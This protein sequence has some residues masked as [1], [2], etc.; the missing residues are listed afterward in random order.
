MEHPLHGPL[1]HTV[2]GKLIA[3]NVTNQVM[4]I[5]LISFDGEFDG[6]WIVPFSDMTSISWDGTQLSIY[7]RDALASGLALSDDALYG[8]YQNIW[9]SP[10]FWRLDAR[11]N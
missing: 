5:A 1:N 2:T 10:G 11:I 4:G 8:Y 6:R 7:S 9:L 3:V